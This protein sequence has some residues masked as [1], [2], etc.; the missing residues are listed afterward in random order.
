[1]LSAW[2]D[3]QRGPAQVIGA[4]Y[5]WESYHRGLHAH[6]RQAEQQVNH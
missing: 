3:E 6:L 5:V 4:L 1:V 2:L